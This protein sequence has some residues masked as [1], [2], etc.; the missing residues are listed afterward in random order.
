MPE[1][2]YIFSGFGSGVLSSER[3]AGPIPTKSGVAHLPRT[4][5][6]QIT[7]TLVLDV[8]QRL[9]ER[10][11]HP[12][13]CGCLT[14]LGGSRAV[15]TVH[16]STTIFIEGLQDAVFD[17]L[18]VESMRV[19]RAHVARRLAAGER[20]CFP[21]HA[22]C[23]SLKVPGKFPRPRKTLALTLALPPNLCMKV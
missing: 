5:R 12:L 20:D 13:R 1:A 10:F 19:L 4:E 9:G 18:H 14:V 17:I 11:H 16:F 3:G 6:A 8:V 15:A 7:P 23:L 2:S 21:I 22:L